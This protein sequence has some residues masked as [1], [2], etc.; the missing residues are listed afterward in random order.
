MSYKKRG[1]AGWNGSKT[2]KERK[3]IERNHS[4]KL[5]AEAEKEMVQGDEYRT[6]A[7]SKKQNKIA[8]KQYWLDYYKR[9]QL[10]EEIKKERAKAKGERYSDNRWWGFSSYRSRIQELEKEIEE[11]KKCLK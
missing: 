10:E 8:Q 6:P 7:R 4:K 11:M 1:Q 2:A 3:Y 9:R 5:I